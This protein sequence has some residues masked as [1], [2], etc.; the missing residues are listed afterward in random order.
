MHPTVITSLKEDDVAPIT[1]SHVDYCPRFST[2]EANDGEP[3]VIN[4]ARAML[5]HAR[6]E[7]FQTRPFRHDVGSWD[8]PIQDGLGQH[9]QES[10]RLTVLSRITVPRRLPFSGRDAKGFTLIE[11]RL[12]RDRQRVLRLFGPDLQQC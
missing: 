12:L 7:L 9:A 8:Q 5:P 1:D 10:S 6:I 4:F 2:V 3:D 11:C